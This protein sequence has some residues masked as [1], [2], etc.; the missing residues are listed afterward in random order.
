MRLG[1]TRV[2]SLAANNARLLGVVVMISIV[3][4]PVYEAAAVFWR[5]QSRR[6]D[7]RPWRE[8]AR[9]SKRNNVEVREETGR[10]AASEVRGGVRVHG[11]ECVSVVLE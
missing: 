7:V 8:V 9:G 5:C 6:G 1:L 10:S 2:S 4:A 11:W 3:E